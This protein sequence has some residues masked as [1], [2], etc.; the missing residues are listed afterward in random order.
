[1]PSAMLT[2]TMRT[3]SPDDAALLASLAA[4]TFHD[5]FAADNTPGNMAAYMAEAFG[6]SI[7]RT[8]LADDRTTVFLAECGDEVAGYVMLRDR[9]GPDVVP[10]DPIEI[11]R[12]YVVLRYLGSG[13]GS[14]LMQCCIDEAATRGRS[15][16]WLG[17]W[18]RNARAIAVYERWGFTDVGT[19]AFQ[20]GDDQQTD[21]IMVRPLV[22]GER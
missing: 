22:A 13:V 18:E 2:I 17:V 14:A 21:R 1:M 3:A 16:L 20:L 4:R 15:T 5:T 12:L 11:V 19:Q 7:Q 6:E 10:G 8:E 9:P